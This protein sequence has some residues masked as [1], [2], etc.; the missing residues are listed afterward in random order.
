MVRVTAA[1]ALIAC[2]PKPTPA[3]PLPPPTPTAPQTTPDVT[4]RYEIIQADTVAGHAVLVRHADGSLDE[5][6]EFNDRGR[7]PKTHAKVAMG[8]DGL[9][10]RVEIAGKDYF[11]RDV[12]EVLSCDNARCKWDSNDEH[13]D[14]ARALFLPLNSTAA[15]DA[16]MLKLASQSSGVKLLGG[17]TA[18]ARRVGDAA[19]ARGGN[20]I[21]VDAWEL[22]GLGFQPYVE[23]FDD[24]GAMFAAV[25][26]WGG[27]IREGW[28][29]IRQQLV[30]AQRG[31]RQERLEELAKKSSHRAGKLAIDRKSVV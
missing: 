23:W 5:D 11:K 31:F 1:L 26:D 2:T 10:D 21:H 4:L 22:S 18:H 27:T 8:A 30:E 9:P 19:F 13:G 14:E 24:T 15:L 25:G 28:S 29:E 17:G 16:P 20:A 7:G 3:P 6:Y 12:R